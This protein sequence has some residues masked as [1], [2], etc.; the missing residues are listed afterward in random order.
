MFFFHFAMSLINKAIVPHTATI[1]VRD[2]WLGIELALGNEL[3]RF[4]AVATVNAAS[5][6]GQI[7]AVH[8]RQRQSLR[9]VVQRS[10]VTIAF[11]RT[12]SHEKMDKYAKS[13]YTF[14]S[15]AH[16]SP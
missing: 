10:T 7:L 1:G 2:Q 3:Q 4:L 9:L 5:L 11:G 6:E 15:S 14:S 12:N 16:A 8:I 13:N